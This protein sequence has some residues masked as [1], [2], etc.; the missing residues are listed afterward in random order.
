M[1][2]PQSQWTV[3]CTGMHGYLERL[4]ERRANRRPIELERV[5]DETSAGL[6]FIGDNHGLLPLRGSRG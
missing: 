4:A 3:N 6:Y 1:S 5:T 2:V